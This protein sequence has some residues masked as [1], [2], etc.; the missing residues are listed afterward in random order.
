MPSARACAVLTGLLWLCVLAKL[1]FY[2]SF[3]PLWEGYD[4]FP[5][6]ALV[7]RRVE[8]HSLPDLKNAI[9]PN[10][11][12]ESLRRLPVP[13]TIRNWTP[14]WTPHDEYWLGHRAEPTD[15]PATELRL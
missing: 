8:T 7:E 13:W 4:E 15:K 6:F 3:V 9:F 2:S 10:D 12:A 5:N 11:V 1:I 14:G